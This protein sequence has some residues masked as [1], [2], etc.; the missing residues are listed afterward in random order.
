M[1]VVVVLGV[2]QLDV[3][4]VLNMCQMLLGGDGWVVEN[5]MGVVEF[6]NDFGWVWFVGWI[7]CDDDWGFERQWLQLVDQIGNCYWLFVWFIVVG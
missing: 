4:F 2:G 3:V 5:W 6:G 7:Q 1:E